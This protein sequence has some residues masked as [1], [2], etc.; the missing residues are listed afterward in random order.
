MCGTV[1]TFTF[2]K[3]SWKQQIRRKFKN[4]RAPPSDKRKRTRDENSENAEEPPPNKPSKKR[5]L[6]K[7]SDI[8]ATEEEEEKYKTDIKSLQEECA[9]DKPSKALVK[10]LMNDTLAIRRNWIDKE[11]PTV[12]E[13]LENFPPL[14]MSSIYVSCKIRHNYA[15]THIILLY[16]VFFFLYSA[17]ERVCSSC[18][19]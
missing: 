10:T 14:K 18:E 7:N 13:I 4:L 17:S 15:C 1:Y 11:G 3:G 19:K 5:K 6:F 8:D 16:L 2:I 12:Y 9:K